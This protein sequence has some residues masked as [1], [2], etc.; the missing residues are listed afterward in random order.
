MK[1]WVVMLSVLTL[2]LITPSVSGCETCV[3]AGA[4]D[5]VG[6][7]KA[8]DRCY[9]IDWGRY[10][11]CYGECTAGAGTG[12]PVPG[13]VEPGRIRHQDWGVAVRSSDVKG[14]A[15][16]CAIDV[17]GRCTAERVRV[18]SFLR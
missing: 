7:V 1:L 2:S 9:S 6:I 3:Y 5:P 16:D 14:D 11:W 17:S 18:E 15:T 4:Q 10:T 12:C 13:S 8:Y